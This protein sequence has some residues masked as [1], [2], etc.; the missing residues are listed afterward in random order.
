MEEK[1]AQIFKKIVKSTYVE[2]VKEKYLDASKFSDLEIG[3]INFISENGQVRFKEITTT[4]EIPKSTL[5]NLINRLEKQEVLV[6]E[7]NPKDKRSYL[8]TLTEKGI[9]VQKDCLA[10]EKEIYSKMLANLS[11]KDKK[12]LLK[13]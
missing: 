4:L 3:V 11:N 8:L 1:L 2:N 7:R 9:S 10:M 5:T 13:L 6:R 12:D